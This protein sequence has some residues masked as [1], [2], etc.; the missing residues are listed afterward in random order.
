MPTNS[1]QSSPAHQSPR[2]RGQGRNEPKRARPPASR[3]GLIDVLG[4]CA[5]QPA[6]ARRTV[7][8]AACIDARSD[9][10]HSVVLTNDPTVALGGSIPAGNV[11]YQ[12]GNQSANLAVTNNDWRMVM[13]GVGGHPSDLASWLRDRLNNGL[14]AI[15]RNEQAAVDQAAKQADQTVILLA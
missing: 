11:T 8:M 9:T 1:R 4:W 14:E 15:A 7:V 10:W 6:G 2:T 3:S 13:R 12:A 5:E